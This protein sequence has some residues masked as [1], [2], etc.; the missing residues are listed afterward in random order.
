MK[1]AGHFANSKLWER[2]FARAVLMRQ[3]FKLCFRW[4]PGGKMV[5]RVNFNHRQK[6]KVPG[7]AS[8]EQ[9]PLGA[10]SSLLYTSR[11]FYVQPWLG[12][13]RAMN[14]IELIWAPQPGDAP[15]SKGGGTTGASPGTPFLRV[16]NRSPA[17]LCPSRHQ[18]TGCMK[19]QT[20]GS[21]QKFANFTQAP[22]HGGSNIVYFGRRYTP[23]FPTH[24]SDGGPS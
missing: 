20:R 4:P 6:N 18:S 21:R 5:Q 22:I 15:V 17:T 7:D 9:L 23:S 1:D 11:G 14:N 13:S 19:L 2:Q 8:Q 3:R 24:T 10:R 12:Q 16:V